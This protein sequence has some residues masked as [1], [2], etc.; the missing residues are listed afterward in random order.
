V[1]V[2]LALAQLAALRKGQVIEVV[3][4]QIEHEKVSRGT[5]DRFALAVE[6][7]RVVHGRPVKVTV[8]GI[9]A[10]VVQGLDPGEGILAAPGHC[11]REQLVERSKVLQAAVAFDAFE[12]VVVGNVL[13]P[14]VT[15]TLE[16]IPSALPVAQGAQTK[17]LDK[18][19][20]AQF[21]A[22]ITITRIGIRCDDRIEKAG[23]YI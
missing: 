8:A 23:E 3:G 22:I 19:E 11:L 17:C 13:A 12:K 5:F 9:N 10:E 7:A 6:S 14:V 15:M 1:H 16:E 2:V 20:I 21:P 4:T 18:I